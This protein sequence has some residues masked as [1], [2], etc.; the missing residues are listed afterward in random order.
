MGRSK[1]AFRNDRPR[2]GKMES[3]NFHW[4]KKLKSSAAVTLT[5]A[6]LLSGAGCAKH[7]APL[8]IQIQNEIPEWIVE[9]EDIVLSVNTSDDN[10]VTEAYVQLDDGSKQPL[11]KI[12]GE[13]S[14]WETTLKLPPG[15][16]TFSVVASDK[17]NEAKVDRE[18]TV[19]PSD[20]DNDGISYRDEL[21][22]GTDSNQPNPIA[23]YALDKDLGTY[24]PQLLSLENDGVVDEK[25]K[26][27]VDLVAKYPKAGELV[28]GIYA[29]LLLLP[30]ISN[31]KY[32]KM[33]NDDLTAIEKILQLASNPG[34]KEAFLQMKNA[35]IPDKR[36]YCSPFE[37]LLWEAY[38]NKN[39]DDLLKQ[40][41]LE[42]LVKDA[43]IHT[44]KSGKYESE[45]WKSFDEVVDRLSFPKG[46]TGSQKTILDVNQML[47]WYYAT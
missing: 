1:Y 9:G 7:E 42:R 20:A 29:E 6:L 41:S 2:L 47:I 46:P 23:K 10:G 36:K 30:D 14:A 11:T 26:A 12:E 24:L 40:F 16:H 19:Y 4:G 31:E 38:D 21:K 18:V 15:N 33:D 17:S 25:D 43:W 3:H 28:P 37:A 39:L 27:F 5:A 32:S 44:S 45:R 35:G 22:L 34:N 13:T 8:T